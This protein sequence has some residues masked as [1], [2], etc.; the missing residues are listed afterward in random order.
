MFSKRDPSNPYLADA[1]RRISKMSPQ[2]AREYS[3]TIWGYGMR[4]AE[5]PAE[6]L[7]DDLSE[8]DMAMATLQAVRERMS[9]Q[10][11]T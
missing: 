7:A 2:A 8:W 5:N 11:T 4:V 10:I 9:G 6:H 1:R 3:V